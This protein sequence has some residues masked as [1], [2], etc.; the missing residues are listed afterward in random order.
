MSPETLIG[1][2]MGKSVLQR[3]RG[4]GTMGAVYM[5]SQAGRQVAVKVFLPASA[6]EQAEY[7]EFAKRLEDS[8]AQAASLDHPHILP[9]L[10]HGRQAGLVYLVMPYI[11]SESLEML[12]N[13]SGA[14]P[15]I[16]AQLYLTQM[17]AA[18]DYAH[19]RGMLHRDVKPANILLAPDGNALLSDFG[20][21]GLTTEKNFARARRALPGMLNTIAP[22]YVL[23]KAIDPRADLYSLGAVLYQMVTGVPLFQEGSLAD[24]AMKHVKV[25]PPSPCS[26]RPDLPRAAGEVILRALAKQ[27]DE[28]YAYA[29]DLASAFQLALEAV[30]PQSSRPTNALDMLADL[31]SGNT[32]SRPAAPRTGGLFDPKWQSNASLPAV[33]AFPTP[34]TQSAAA[35]PALSLLSESIAP[36]G[37]ASQ[38]NFGTPTEQQDTAPQPFAPLSADTTSSGFF[39]PPTPSGNG[40]RRSGL[41]SFA[42]NP[43]QAVPTEQPLAQ[44]QNQPGPFANQALQ[45][46]DSAGGSTDEFSFAPP[47]P[48]PAPAGMFGTFAGLPDNAEHTNAGKLTDPVKIVQMPVAGQPGRFMTGFLPPASTEQ[49]EQTKPRRTKRWLKVAVLLMLVLIVGAASS[50]FL[51]TRS[52][53]GQTPT[54]K[55]PTTHPMSASDQATATANANVI[56][57]DALSQNI[58]NW[59][60]GS[61]GWYTCAFVDGAYHITNNDSKRSAA[62]LLPGRVI[63]APFAY[64]LT[65]EQIKGDETVL[66]NLF[67]VILDASVQDVQGKQIDKFYAFE[68]LNKAGGQYQFWKYD[69]SKDGSPWKSLWTKN[70]GKEFSQGSGP[71]H[72]NT[73][74]IIATGTM[75]T[76]IVNGTQVGTFKDSSFSSGTVGMLVNLNGAEI[77]F[78]H[79]LVTHV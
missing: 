66:N 5:A 15:L 61:Q 63:N 6:L 37:T 23:G 76:F 25:S 1:M 14:L 60:V 47:Q 43:L 67:G 9:V 8:I 24:V 22:E 19:A 3:L 56:L 54:T 58:H 62:A 36:T 13:R 29:R 49:K 78:S 75:F 39:V 4:Q 2:E 20:L 59:P 35:Q 28:R 38:A 77:A 79:L 70:F 74:K 53:N 18:L 16:Q 26:L 71:S 51:L 33:G 32:A 55:K 21:A 34:G 10:D 7:E 65:M 31:A 57:A 41:L 48:V 30:S 27:P 12:L 50:V 52:Q 40:T 45:L 73:V 17:A 69:N 46:A 64:S 11:E 42:Q 68:V 44:D 72:I